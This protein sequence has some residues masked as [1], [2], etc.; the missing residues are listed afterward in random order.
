MRAS[1]GGPYTRNNISQSRATTPLYNAT[2]RIDVTGRSR[3]TGPS[4]RDIAVTSIPRHR[5]GYCLTPDRDVTDGTVRSNRA[6]S[7]Y[8]SPCRCADRR[9]R[10]GSGRGR[11]RFL[12]TSRASCYSAPAA[13]P[14]PSSPDCRRQPKA[15]PGG[16]RL[17]ARNQARRIQH[18]GAAGTPPACGNGHNFVYRGSPG[19]SQAGFSSTVFQSGKAAVATMP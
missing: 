15:P 2:M 9:S 3:R 1:Q 12:T 16:H 11:G 10:C 13:R 14:A 17:A 8:P 19:M 7:A 4:R 5:H 6:H 18:G